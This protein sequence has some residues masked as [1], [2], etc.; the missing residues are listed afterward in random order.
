MGDWSEFMDEMRS[1]RNL[2]LVV[3]NKRG[4]GGLRCGNRASMLAEMQHRLGAYFVAEWDGESEAQS[5]ERMAEAGG[6][7]F[8][9]R[10]D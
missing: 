5:G 9:Q 4:V 2:C 7:E 1:R 6:V 10:Q 3:T 8:R